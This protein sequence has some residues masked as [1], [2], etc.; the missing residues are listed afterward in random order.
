M[1][2]RTVSDTAK[3]LIK[4]NAW[5]AFFVGCVIGF[6][7]SDAWFAVFGMMGAFFTFIAI[8]AICAVIVSRVN[9]EGE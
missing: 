6:V 3:V 8:D 7:A 9:Q 5:P 4:A 2:N 1:S